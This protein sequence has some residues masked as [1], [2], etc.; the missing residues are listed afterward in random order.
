MFSVKI[1]RLLKIIPQVF[2]LLLFSIAVHGQY[3]SPQ[4]REWALGVFAGLSFATGSPVALH[5]ELVSAEGCAS[6]CD[7]NGKLLFYTNG[8]S[9][10]DSTHTVM[11]NGDTICPFSTQSSSQGALIAPVLSTLSE[12]GPTKYYI[13]SL[14]NFD[15][16]ISGA[17]TSAVNLY[18]SIVDMDLNGGHGDIVPGMSGIHLASGLTE[19]MIAIPGANCDLW[20][21]VHKLGEPVF[22]AYNVNAWGID[23]T[24][25]ISHCGEMSGL[26][27][28]GAGVLKCS[29]D[30]SK[31]ASTNSQTVVFSPTGTFSLVPTQLGSELFDFDALTGTLSNCVRISTGKRTYGLEFSPD[32]KKLYITHLD[33]DTSELVQFDITDT[34]TIQASK[35]V[36]ARAYGNFSDLR[37]AP[38][39]KIYFRW[40]NSPSSLSRIATPNAT[41]TLCTFQPD[42]VPLLALTAAQLG[43]GNLYQLPTPVGD[44]ITSASDTIVCFENV[45]SV[46]LVSP[47]PYSLWGNGSTENSRTVGS[48]GSFVVTS[49]SGC[50]VSKHTFNIHAQET[51]CVSSVTQN[52]NNHD[53]I[54]LF[55]N[56]ASAACTVACE[57]CTGGFTITVSDVSGRVLATYA[58]TQAT[59][60]LTL[61]NLS[62]GLYLL[63]VSYAEKAF[64]RKLKIE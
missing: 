25:V 47:F 4:N 55:P 31:V 30:Y 43:I 62:T 10:W 27:A 56:P 18:Y 6:V 59:S 33:G 32:S 8:R 7:R 48:S 2:S 29:P 21:I 34:A 19:R 45:D 11:P 36:V 49:I 54:S 15:Y 42:A 46:T 57:S 35:Y 9:V 40:G 60:Q 38:D 24:P 51:P 64:Y 61:K 20:I 44:T 13:F 5:T 3:N 53:G 22:E 17:D 39:N 41:G 28:Y 12:G 37:L 16:F 63:K 50:A 1:T 52:T 23:T 14:Q 58:S 26:W